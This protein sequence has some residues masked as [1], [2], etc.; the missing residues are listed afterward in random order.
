ML[1]IV[2][3]FAQLERETIQIRIRDNYYARGKKG[4][5]LGGP[6]P[7]GFRK[8]EIRTEQGRLKLLEPNP[9]TVE[10]LVRIF[11]MYGEDMIPQTQILV[12]HVQVFQ[13]LVAVVPPILEPLQI[14]I[15]LAEEFQLHL[16]ELPDTE[17]KVARRNLIAER[18]A[19]LAHAEG[20]LAAGG[21]LDVGEVHKNTLSGLGA[22]I[23][24]VGGILRNALM[25]LEHQVKFADV[26]KVG[27]SAARARD[28]LFPDIGHQILTGHANQKTVNKNL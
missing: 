17:N 1:T 16:L 3:T 22:E 23:N 19:H 6:P 4:M 9:D 8:T 12:L 2:M 21:A 7:F 25:R 14:G 24:L 27:L 20:E 10:T 18:L 5:Y 11:R 28:L 15:R 26:G 13:P